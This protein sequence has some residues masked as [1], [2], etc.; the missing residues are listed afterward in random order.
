MKKVNFKNALAALVLAMVFLVVGI[1]RANAQASTTTIAGAP[2]SGV[3]FKSSAQAQTDLLNAINTLKTALQNMIPGSAI[4]NA[5]FIQANYYGGIL[6][7]INAG[8]SVSEAIQAGLAYAGY[9]TGTF[10]STS[11]V[12]RSQI[13]AMIQDATNLLKL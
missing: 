3:T 10:G 4:Y 9:P 12:S 5:T 2:A 8:K 6:A 7:E 1:E 11:P 13:M